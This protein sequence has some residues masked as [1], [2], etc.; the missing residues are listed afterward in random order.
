MVFF[1]FSKQVNITLIV[2][3]SL[4]F[5]YLLMTTKELS[6]QQSFQQNSRRQN[7]LVL[8]WIIGVIFIDTLELVTN[9][10]TPSYGP[11]YDTTDIFFL[12]KL[13]KFYRFIHVSHLNEGEHLNFFDGKIYG[14]PKWMIPILFKISYAQVQNIFVQAEKFDTFFQIKISYLCKKCFS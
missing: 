5:I 6:C 4:L 7:C 2:V 3:T 1:A 11:R 13:G 9:S 10:K 8:L 12:D 14:H